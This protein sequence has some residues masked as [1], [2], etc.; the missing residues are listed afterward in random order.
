MRNRN[1]EQKD[2]EIMDFRY[3]IIAELLNPYLS[4]RERANLMRQKANRQYEI[5]Y[6]NKTSL[7]AECIKKWYATFKQFG[8]QGLKPKPRSDRG[9]SRGLT[10]E[11]EA[12][13]LEYL[14][15]NPELTAKATFKKLQE[16][17]VITH[18]IS[19][20]SLSRLVVAAGLERE[21]RLQH[22][23]KTQKLKFAFKYP[24]ECPKVLVWRSL[25]KSC[26]SG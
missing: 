23:H 5:P 24:L 11:E 1:Q 6:S 12:A 16:Q 10:P 3:S 17:G 9:R 18:H 14:E 26:G 22:K 20:S 19:K 8:K 21:T 2:Q 15:Q 25:T 13:F 7:S 4:R